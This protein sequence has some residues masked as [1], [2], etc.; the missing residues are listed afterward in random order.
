MNGLATQ[1]FGFVPC[2]GPTRRQLILTNHNE[3]L[4]DRLVPLLLPP[5]GRSMRIIELRDD[6]KKGVSVKSW[7]V[8]G[9]SN[10]AWTGRSPLR[11][12]IPEG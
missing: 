8:K 5:A 4:T 11:E 9:E 7:R 12:L 1:S 2:E 10:A 6:P 3:H